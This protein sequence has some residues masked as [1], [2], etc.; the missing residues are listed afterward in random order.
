MLHLW[1]HGPYNYFFQLRPVVTFSLPVIQFK[2]EQS[3]I[4]PTHNRINRNLIKLKILNSGRFP[5]DKETSRIQNIVL[6]TIKQSD[7]GIDV[8]A[9]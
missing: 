8:V 5:P 3:D 2:R 4:K 9:I 7:E 6:F 1:F